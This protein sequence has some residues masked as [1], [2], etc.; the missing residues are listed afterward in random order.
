MGL[1]NMIH[2]GQKLIPH[3]HL[4]INGPKE[5][6]IAF[7][8]SRRDTGVPMEG[9]IRL[10]DRL[11]ERGH[12]NVHLLVLDDAHHNN[13]L[14]ASDRDRKNYIEFVSNLGR[15]YCQQ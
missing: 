8:T 5:I 11:R 12:K 4:S 1:H 9:T 13:Y 2:N 14:T 10:V 6:P 7:V 15:L 3:W